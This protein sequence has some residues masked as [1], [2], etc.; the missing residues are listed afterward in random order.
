MNV[1]YVSLANILSGGETV[2]Y[3]KSHPQDVMAE[4][5][6][7]IKNPDYRQRMISR[8]KMIRAMFGGTSRRAA[9]MVCEMAGW[10]KG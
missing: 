5:R 2:N 9:E 7:I 10:E 6:E 1:K 8:L 4:L 3:K